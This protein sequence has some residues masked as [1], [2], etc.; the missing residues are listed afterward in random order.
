MRLA[1]WFVLCAGGLLGQSADAPKYTGPGSCASPSCHG[2]VQVRTE[3]SVQQNEYSTW[4]VQD[5]HAHA[6]AVLTNPAATRMA[7]ILKIDKADSAPKCLGCHALSVPEAE[8]A[9]T[10]DSTDGV[11]CESCHGPASNWLGPHTTKG[12]THERS[13]A[14][15]MRD[16]RD[17]IR[18]S[19]NCLGC[20][21]GNADKAV[22]HEMIAAGHPDLYFELASFTAAMP[23]HWK[24]RVQDDPQIEVRLLAAGQAVQLR[25]QLQRVA[26]NTQ[27]N[28]WP[29]FADLDCFACHHNLTSSENSWRQE[30]GYTG[31]KAGSPPWNLSR[32][33]VLRQIANEV[34]RDNGRRLETEI[35]KLYGIMSATNA[36]RNQAATQARATS[37]IAGRLAQQIAAAPFDQAR[38]QRLLQSIARDGDYISRQGERAAEQVAMALQ[39][40]YLTYPAQARA[41]NDTQIRSA[42]KALF[43]QVEN[44]SAYNAPKFAE[45][46]RALTQVLP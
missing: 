2:G 25:E 15:G 44:P 28:A 8:R 33:A 23:R 41:A 21:L 39:S 35:E 13:V 42:L 36:D 19:E 30:L 24:E 1:G 10:F 29:E 16:L 34:D 45:A 4:V 26:R 31:R 11:S 3:T 32:Y 17:S 46:M 20:H 27:G 38:T 43:Q 9:R 14:A 22:D 7:R 6:F 18:R 12:W 40:L 5:K 37:E